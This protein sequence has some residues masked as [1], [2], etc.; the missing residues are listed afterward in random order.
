MFLRDC[1]V[2]PEKPFAI[3]YFR[4]IN[5]LADSSCGADL[6]FRRQLH[7]LRPGELEAF[8]VHCLVKDLASR[9]RR[10]PRCEQ[11]WTRSGLGNLLLGG[12][13]LQSVAAA[14]D[15]VGWRR[16]VSPAFWRR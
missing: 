1:F 2:V 12:L 9:F 4:G 14:L 3:H 5:S 16:P 15:G 10:E 8:I 7:L 13:V 6:S 11:P